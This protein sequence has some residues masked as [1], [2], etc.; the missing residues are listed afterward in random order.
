MARSLTAQDR[1][2]LLLALVPYLTVH[3][4][5]PVRELAEAFDVPAKVL[6]ELIAFLGT[7]GV[8]GETRTYQ[9]ED[10]FD[11]DWVAFEEEDLVRLTKVIAVDDAPRFSAGEYA[12]LLAGL[13]AV[14]PLLPETERV[15][16][17]GAAAKLSAALS[18][19]STSE[20]SPALSVAPEAENPVLTTIATAIEHGVRLGFEYR[21][22]RGARSRRA[23]EPLAL[24]QSR[25]G[26]YLRAHCLDREAER[27][28]LVDG[29]RD[30]ELSDVPATH[31][32]VKRPLLSVVGPSET[33]IVAEVCVREQALPRIS[34]FSPRVLGPDRP[35]WLRVTIDLA[36]PGAAI[37]LVAL[38][39]GDVVVHA[40]ESARRA[41]HEWA[42]RGRA[43]YDA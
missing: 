24:V 16:A 11:I 39:P 28:F 17:K 20:T 22:V 30:A 19:R 42:E 10:L 13:N 18:G 31:R 37:R 29:I 43:P 36:Y 8:P 27:T 1:V 41:V 5:T 26:W 9:D 32:P 6:R 38:A 15:H 2:V 35:G 14:T 25:T 33:P 21:D 4:A 40:P 23:V 34:S 3:G 12:A 7:A